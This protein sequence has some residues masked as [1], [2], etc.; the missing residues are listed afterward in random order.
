MTSVS[1]GGSDGKADAQD[2][3][4][5]H[6]RGTRKKIVTPQL[7]L[8]EPAATVMSGVDSVRAVMWGVVECGVLGFAVECG[9][10]GMSEVVE[11]GVPWAF[12]GMDLTVVGLDVETW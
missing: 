4:F 1:G 7:S 10:A 9:C 3:N 6:I 11:C 5:V 12:V 2:Y 8:E